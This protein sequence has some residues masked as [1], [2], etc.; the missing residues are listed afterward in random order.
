[1]SPLLIFHIATASIAVMAGMAAMFLRKG[2]A[3]HRLAGTIF[4]VGMICM[5]LSAIPLGLLKA[6]TLN[7]LVGALTCYLVASGWMAGRHDRFR[8]AR[9]VNVALGV[10]ALG[11][12]A[13]LVKLGIEAIDRRQGVLNIKFHK[14]ARIPPDRLMSLVS[15]TEGAQFTP[16]G[17][18]R[19][20]VDGT[21]GAAKILDLIEAR[22]AQLQP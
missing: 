14:E 17:V 5:T 7:A 21:G 4:G 6:Q 18:L 13:L 22:L 15:E 2:S 8:Y 9:L 11:L 16:A 12:G 20:P 3:R 1:M 10:M 19:L